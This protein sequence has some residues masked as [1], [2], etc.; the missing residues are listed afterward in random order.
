[1]TIACLLAN[2]LSAARPAATAAIGQH[3]HQDVLQIN[4]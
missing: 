2:T 1:M 4:I 3:V